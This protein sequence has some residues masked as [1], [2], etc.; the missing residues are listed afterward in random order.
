MIIETERLYVRK[1]EDN[2][3]DINFYYRLWNSGEVMKYVSFPEGLGITKR[4]IKKILSSY[5]ESAFDKTLIIVEKK[6]Q[7]I[8]GECKLGFPNDE[9]LSITDVKLLPEYWGNGYGKEIKKALCHYLFSKTKCEIVK[10]DPNKLNIAS[11]KMQKACGG[12]KVDETFYE[13]PKNS[14]I[15]RNNIHAF[16]YHI[17]KENFYRKFP[18]YKKENLCIN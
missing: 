2:E 15:K 7:N 12:I 18:E 16:V 3:K 4:E 11:Q 6:A 8:I 5:N 9:K 14:K 1:A 17:K 13:A 10:A